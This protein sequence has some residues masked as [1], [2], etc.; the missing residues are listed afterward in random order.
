MEGR[1]VGTLAV[2]DQDAGQTVSLEAG[3]GYQA[4]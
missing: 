3:T 1:D 2:V 4:D